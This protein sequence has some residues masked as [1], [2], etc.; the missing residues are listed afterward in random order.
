MSLAAK[1]RILATVVT[2]LALWPLAHR[3][4][5]ARYRVSPWRLFGWAMYCI[6]VFQPELE[7]YAVGADGS[8][9]AP[10]AFPSHDP[11]HDLYRGSFVHARFQLGELVST[12]SLARVMFEVHPQ[13]DRLAVVVR[14]TYYELDTAMLRERR[15]RTVYERPP[16]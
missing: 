3:Y 12:D 1:R 10:L 9:G 14:Q 13:V 2:V 5:V 11:D 16:P 7:Y 6:P 15:Y 4:V 8:T